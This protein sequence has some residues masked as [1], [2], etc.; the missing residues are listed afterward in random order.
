MLN[1][2]SFFSCYCLR[3]S[4]QFFH[5]CWL[6]GFL[7]MFYPFSK[8]LVMKN[9][10]L[11]VSLAVL[12]FLFSWSTFAIYCFSDYEATLPIDCPQEFTGTINTGDVCTSNWYV[13]FNEI[14]FPWYCTSN[15]Y[16]LSWD[17]T[18]PTITFPNSQEITITGDKIMQT[19]MTWEWLLTGL[20]NQF[21]QY[22]DW[23]GD[24]IAPVQQIDYEKQEQSIIR[25]I[26]IGW[27]MLILLF[28]ILYLIRGLFVKLWK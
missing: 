2:Y 14:D 8:N 28:V 13:L 19:N 6:F 20:N 12:W 24:Y 11:I 27:S 5:I 21:L 10:L 25:W 7:S 3:F 22:I 17:F 15:G 9:K 16:L 26:A 18:Y 23:S 4:F 1:F